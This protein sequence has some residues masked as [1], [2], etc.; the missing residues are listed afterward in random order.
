MANGRITQK[1]QEILNYIKAVIL[2]KGYPPSVREIC[3]AVGLKST[4]SVHSHLETLERNGF[5]R[6]DPSKPRTIEI[7]DDSFQAVRTEIAS[8]PVIG[9]VAAGTPI[10]A[11]EHI[12]KYFPVPT[13][14]LPKGGRYFALQ[15][16]GDSMINL[17]IFDGD[18]VFV[19]ECHTAENGQL[20]VALVDDS[21]TLK[22]FFKEEDHIRLQPEND[23]MDPIIVEDCLILGKRFAVFRSVQ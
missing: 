23:H 19:H 4:S 2:K 9:N 11:E 3:D 7:C 21:A 18:Y 6:R 5:I 13:E 17:G 22:R 12:E 8:I 15:V 20:V 10:L 14:I 16:H 1:Q